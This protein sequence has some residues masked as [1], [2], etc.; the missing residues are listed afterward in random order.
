L[1]S[2]PNYSLITIKVVFSK[3]IFDTKANVSTPILSSSEK[4]TYLKCRR[5]CTY[6]LIVKYS[7]PKRAITLI[8]M[9]KSNCH[10]KMQICIS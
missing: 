3:V 7:M 9:G 1:V 2:D 6:N 8:K 4:H 5:S 10:N